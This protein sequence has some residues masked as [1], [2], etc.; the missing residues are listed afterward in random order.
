[1]TFGFQVS[2]VSEDSFLFL[3]LCHENIIWSLLLVFYTSLFACIACA[4]DLR[5]SL[6]KIKDEFECFAVGSWYKIYKVSNAY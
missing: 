5:A 1:M 6:V 3:I 4:T 2:V